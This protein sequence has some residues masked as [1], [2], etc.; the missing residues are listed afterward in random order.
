MNRP[1]KR[2]SPAKRT[3]IDVR[4]TSQFFFFLSGRLV[5]LHLQADHR[6]RTLRPTARKG[7]E[8]HRKTHC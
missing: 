1:L 6:A 7:K 3:D 8:K 2:L 5:L 4:V